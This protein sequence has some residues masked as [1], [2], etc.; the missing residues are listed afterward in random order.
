MSPMLGATILFAA[1]WVVILF[2]GYRLYR[3][4]YRFDRASRHGHAPF[5]SGL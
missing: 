5:D 4:L 1:M 2:S 3:W